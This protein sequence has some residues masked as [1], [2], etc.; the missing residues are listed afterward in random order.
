MSHETYST[1]ELA[2]AF[3]IEESTVRAMARDGLLPGADSSGRWVFGNEAACAIEDL[4]DR[5]EAAADEDL[6]DI[7]SCDEDDEG[8]EDDEEDE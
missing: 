3:G 1:T 2:E 4:I 6:E 7:P 5:V 8:D